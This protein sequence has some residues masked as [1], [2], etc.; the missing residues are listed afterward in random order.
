MK[1]TPEAQ[2]RIGQT[3]TV[4][5]RLAF[6]APLLFAALGF[7]VLLGAY[8]NHFDNGFHFDDDHVIEKNAYIR[9][10][11]HVPKFFTDPHTFSSLAP[12]A[13]YRPLLTLSYAL[14][15][16][17]AGGL[18]PRQFHLTQFALLTV[19]W[20]LLILLY[21]HLFRR[22]EIEP[23][24]DPRPGFLGHEP[25]WS[26][27]L[28][29]IFGATLFCV[30]TVN[31]HTV[32][33]LSSRSSLMATLGIVGSLILY[34]AWPRQR[35]TFIYLLPMSICALA[36]PLA[37]VFAPILY[38]YILLL[39]PGV[40]LRDIRLP[41]FWAHA[42]RALKTSTPAFIV[43]GALFLFVSHMNA[44]TFVY[45][46]VGRL[47]YLHS[48]AFAWLHY[49]RLFFVPLGL[50]A[51]SDWIAPRNWYD[52][53]F[54]AG[55]LFLFILAATTQRLSKTPRLRPAALGL[56]WFAVGLLPTSSIFPLYEVYN[57]HRPFLPYVG[58][59]LTVTWCGYLA[60][61]R[62]RTGFLRGARAPAFAIPLA[63]CLIGALAW[64]THS[65][66][67]TWATEESLW[68]DVIRKS[69]NNGRALMNYGIE[70]MTQG[71]PGE[72]LELFQRALLFLP[73]Y[74]A[75]H[76]NV[77]IA[78]TALGDFPEAEKS[79][80][81]ALELSPRFVQG[82]YFYGLYLAE[83]GRAPEAIAQLQIGLDLSTSDLLTRTLLTRIYA[84]I[85]DTS[86]AKSIAAQTLLLVSQNPVAEACLNDTPP[87]GAGTLDAGNYLAQA[88][89]KIQKGDFLSAAEILTHG[90]RESPESADQWNDLGYT[91][92]KLGFPEISV[93]CFRNA[94]RLD[95]NHGKAKGNLE[96][97]LELR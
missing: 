72:A 93:D 90:V 36:K 76:I 59:T 13:A 65:R 17:L 45:G 34:I 35:G 74:P 33:Y 64:G 19:I 14:D 67:R 9:S 62:A 53:R 49:A 28:L 29:A 82:H 52:T 73:D 18:I 43:G 84:A 47:E 80:Q 97:A 85:G 20:G 63:A 23:E 87:I 46:S 94:L 41:E 92:L 32:N 77:G 37:I 50:T 7:L 75:L 1:V 55:L 58:L 42:W 26:H 39:E 27:T 5:H 6:V 44:D 11:S 83:H 66:N 70:Q 89:I 69:P 15:Y 31:S 96:W 4:A 68:A 78:M 61:Q 71:D 22:G 16:H 86:R 24:D 10:L 25:T 48:Q 95:P 3:S 57:E 51:D 21:R 56:A 91:R 54:F 8:S 12:N 88:Q 79:Y 38:C 30:H 40:S 81:Y 2:A 60:V